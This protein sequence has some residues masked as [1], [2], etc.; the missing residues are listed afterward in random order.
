[1]NG[2]RLAIIEPFKW[3]LFNQ[4]GNLLHPILSLPGCAESQTNFVLL[5]SQAVELEPICINTTVVNL[6]SMFDNATK[7]QNVKLEP[8]NPFTIYV[9]ANQLIE[10]GYLMNKN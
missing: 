7:R 8:E 9:A 6:I 4:N 3:I 2:A 10:A 5:N 1:M